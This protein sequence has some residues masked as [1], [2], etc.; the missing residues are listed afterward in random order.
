MIVKLLKQTET[1]NKVLFVCLAIN[2]C[3]RR[4]NS[5]LKYT[6][7][8]FSFANYLLKPCHKI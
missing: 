2:E 6:K 8:K 7:T 1:L 4:G 5:S 3:L